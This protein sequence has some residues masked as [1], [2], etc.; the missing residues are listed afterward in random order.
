MSERSLFVEAS[1]GYLPT[2]DALA[3]WDLAVLP[4]GPVAGLLAR[5]AH[6]LCPH[7]FATARLDVQLHSTTPA[8]RLEVRARQHAARQRVAL[9]DVTVGADGIETAR[10]TALYVRRDATG[11]QPEPQRAFVGAPTDYPR[12]ALP[13]EM[14]GSHAT[15]IEV[16][17]IPRQDPERDAAWVRYDGTVVQGDPNDPYLHASLVADLGTALLWATEDAI[18]HINPTLTIHLHRQPVSP[19]IAVVP[20][21]TYRAS[22]VDHGVCRLHDLDG[23]FATIDITALPHRKRA[24]ASS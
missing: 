20:E 9:I 5:A 3:P 18:E 14:P 15:A 19:W 8:A 12:L 11:C 16:H 24:T 7:G 10:A 4:G 6:Q 1:G 22:S 23:P 17:P 21:T 2:A 13:A